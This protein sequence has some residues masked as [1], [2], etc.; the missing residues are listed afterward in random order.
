MRKKLKLSQ[1]RA[2]AIAGG[3]VLSVAGFLKAAVHI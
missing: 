2:A 3:G 1:R